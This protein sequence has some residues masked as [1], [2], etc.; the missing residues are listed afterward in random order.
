MRNKNWHNLNQ[1]ELFAELKTSRGGLSSLAFDKR[2]LK[3]GKNIIPRK[4]RNTYLEIAL[5]QMKS[6]LVLLLFG[7]ALVSFLLKEFVD[8]GV[9][10]FAV[11]LNTV[12]GFIQEA[13]AEQALAALS[14]IVRH[15]AFVLRDGTEK[16]IDSEDI[17]VGDILILKAGD[18][19]LADG[20]I[21]ENYELEVD[22]SILTGESLP[23]LKI[24]KILKAENTKAQSQKNMVYMGSAVTKG[25]GVV[26]VTSTGLRT[27]FGKIAEL[28][29][30]TEDIET[31]LQLQLNK[32]SRYFGKLTLVIVFLVV[33]IGLY[34]GMAFF[35]IFM[36]SIAIAVAAIPE[37]MLVAVT[38]ILAIG[39]QRTLKNGSLIRKLIAVETL[40]SVTLICTDKTGTLTKGTMQLDHI[41]TISSV[42]RVNNVCREK[43]ISEEN[44]NTEHI[45]ALKIGMV[46]NDA[47]I[48]N[49]QDQ[50][51][52]WVIHGGY[53][54]KA[55]LWAGICAGFDSKHI[56]Q[57]IVRVNEIPFSSERKFMATLN[58]EGGKYMIYVKGA[59]EEIINRSKY[60]FSGGMV[61]KM[62]EDDLRFL[63]RKQ[64]EMSKEGLRVLAV[65][66]KEADS[67]TNVL[68][69]ESNDEN[70]V[71][72]LVFVGLT[73]L[74]DPLRMEAKDT[75]RLAKE[76]GIR[77]IIITGDNALT[78]KAIATELGMKVEDVN[79][80]EGEHLD[81]MSDRDFATVV[82][83]IKVYARV[84]PRHKS[85]IVDA[86]QARGEVVAMTGDGVNDAPA[87]KKADI[88]IALG[89]GTE[90]A[91]ETADVVL[92]DDN[93]KT[94]ISA[95]EQGRIIFENIRKVIL[96]LISDSFSEVVVVMGSLLL[97]LAVPITAPQILW[98]NLVTDG[99]PNVALAFEPG[100]KDVMKQ[101][102][103]KK[104][105]SLFNGEI[106]VLVLAISILSGVVA[107]IV[108][109]YIFQSTGD[110]K[111]ASSVVFS[112]LSIDSL[113]YVFSIRF[114]ESSMFTKNIFSNKYL[115]VA[116]L[117]AFLFQFLAIY[118]PFLQGILQTKALS[119]NDWAI[120]FFVSI[121]NILVIEI[122]KHL[123]II[124][125]NH[126]K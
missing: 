40:G 18:R 12:M 110:F 8:A 99:L 57:R 21:I 104:S 27:K 32:F 94:I 52:D 3:N 97:G 54:E 42:T 15:R 112:I 74:K 37:G 82:A 4:I 96:Y 59:A 106:K 98:I 50:I 29:A 114:L 66:F 16:E 126:K 47:V 107:L 89:S 14:S 105:E 51:E 19:V 31:P 101:K 69:K 75:I 41:A 85:R 46:C 11:A 39:M 87:L 78:A 25:R 44:E 1:E 24:S 70:V 35:D 123:F 5:R 122:I 115:V 10:L 17:V 72:G 56:N 79:I 67:K 6:S 30:N 48:E 93:F 64:I 117:L 20:R 103:R 81:Q 76:A 90:V 34:R 22:E 62:N 125:Q 120:I 28:L 119:L 49:P 102:P 113:L 92:L 116:V 38:I 65:A 83:S 68:F 33:A 121:F 80:M 43:A 86:W 118:N 58:K 23:V 71:N 124:N 91:K 53:T 13:K 77:T 2:L 7:A 100:E 26:V 45:L 9:I 109:N 36:T 95:V 60:V 55:F 73:A 84:S 108:F 111:H 61:R 63:R 88:G